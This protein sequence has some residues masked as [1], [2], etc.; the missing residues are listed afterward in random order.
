MCGE[1]EQ[2]GRRL[3]GDGADSLKWFRA[4]ISA[5]HPTPSIGRKRVA[6]ECKKNGTGPSTWN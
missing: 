5:V 3:L 2:C 6:P 4:G 1:A